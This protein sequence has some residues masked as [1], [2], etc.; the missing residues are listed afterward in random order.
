ME[1]HSLLHDVESLT[2]NPIRS[3]TSTEGDINII[4]A[5]LPSNAYVPDSIVKLAFAY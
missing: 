3:Y 2:V 4:N 1:L 5:S